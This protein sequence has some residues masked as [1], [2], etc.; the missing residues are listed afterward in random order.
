MKRTLTYNAKEKKMLIKV[1]PKDGLTVSHPETGLPMKECAIEK[2]PA[3][4]RLLKDGDL[5]EVKKTAA[6][7]KKKQNP[8]E[9]E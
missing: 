2:T 6:K 7:K 4:I 5:V 9:A 8:S 1:K 3:I